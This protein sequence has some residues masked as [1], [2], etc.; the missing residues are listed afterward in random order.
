MLQSI[1]ISIYGK[2]F[3]TTISSFLK[4]YH[5]IYENNI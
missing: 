5:E 3:Y 1:K 2:R 4:F